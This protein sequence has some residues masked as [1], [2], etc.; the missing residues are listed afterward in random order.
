[1][2][3]VKDTGSQVK[4]SV[5]FARKP[6]GLNVAFADTANSNGKTNIVNNNLFRN[7]IASYHNN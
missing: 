1:L 2:E 3:K 6:L 5:P 7:I 4:N